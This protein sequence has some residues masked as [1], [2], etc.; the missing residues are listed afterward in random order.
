M[1]NHVCLEWEP[2]NGTSR[3]L[4]TCVALSHISCAILVNFGAR[5]GERKEQERWRQTRNWILIVGHSK[6]VGESSVREGCVVAITNTRLTEVDHM[7]VET[8]SNESHAS[9]L[10]ECTSKTVSSNLY[11]VAGQHCTQA[12]YFI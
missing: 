3:V 12:S 1:V 9:K 10:S 2:P 7:N 5:M 11:S 4:S 6:L 8:V